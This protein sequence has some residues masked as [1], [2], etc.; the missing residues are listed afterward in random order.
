MDAEALVARIDRLLFELQAIRAELAG[1]LAPATSGNGLNAHTED[2]LPEHLIEISTAV[3]RFNRPA[4]TLRWLCRTEGYGRKVQGR[5][6]VSAPMLS[7][8]LKRE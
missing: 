5:W 8:R 1:M 2:F 3:E 6:L 7:R 4:D